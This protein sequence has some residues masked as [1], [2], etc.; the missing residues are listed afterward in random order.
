[1]AS[2][3]ENLIAIL[4]EE[5][6]CYEELLKVSGQKTPV[7]VS[8]DLDKLSAI[9]DDEQR[10]VDGI[11][12]LEERREQAMR[13]IADV[14]NRDVRTLTITD[15]VAMLG[16]RPG[17]ARALAKNRDRLKSAADRVRLVNEQNQQLLKSSLEMVQF[18]M[19]LLQSL[20]T[21]PETADYNSN[22][23]ANGTIM[24]SGTKRFDAKQ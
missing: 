12:K 13:D 23:Y 24:G 19:N 5:S 7:I 11:A 9:T 14:L 1:M 21:A 17:E 18:E 2:L 8:G 20:K 15:L 10:V 22:A 6:G 16:K 3:M 4:E